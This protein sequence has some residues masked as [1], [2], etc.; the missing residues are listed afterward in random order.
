MT[1][2][3]IE[4]VQGRS[5]G[6]ALATAPA[7]SECEEDW[8]SKPGGRQGCGGEI[9]SLL[10]ARSDHLGDLVLFSGALRRIRKLFPRTRIVYATP[11]ALGDLVALCPHIDEWRTWEELESA[12]LQCETTG[13]IRG[14]RVP[15]LLEARWR[16]FRQRLGTP[17]AF[18]PDVLIQPMRS[19]WGGETGT[20]AAVRG[21]RARLRFG[22]SGDLSNQTQEDDDRAEPAYTRRL[23][24]GPGDV[25]RHEFDVTAEFLRLLGDQV[26]ASDL[27]PEV[28]TAATDQLW[29]E[30]VFVPSAGAIRIALC[31]GAAMPQKLPDPGIWSS[32]LAAISG[33]RFEVEV[34]GTGSEVDLCGR[35]A[36]SLRGLPNVATVRDWSGL[37]TL[38]RFTEA[39][40]RAELV[41]GPDAG[42]IHVAIALRRPTVA[43]VGG[44]HYGR[45]LPWGDPRINRVVTRRLDR[46]GCGWR[47]VRATC[48]CVGTV[49]A[50]E[51]AAEIDGVLRSR[52]CRMASR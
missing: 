20:H 52:G 4:A 19:P 49:G 12:S 17:R 34:L 2:R 6:A 10:V 31:P 18:R 29:A 38:G 16:R 26:E 36:A 46:F 7:K 25:A 9:H 3:G 11:R 41:V 32:A 51:M 44:G 24:L 45:F 50:N 42:G 1:R 13:R 5:D 40:R 48:E 22:I 47:C 21:I 8:P 37:T 27:W 33:T 15:R 14:V 28:W 35:V 23:R 43:V 39:L 30:E